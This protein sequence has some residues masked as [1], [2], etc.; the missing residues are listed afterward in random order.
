M[1]MLF[2]GWKRQKRAFVVL[3]RTTE[4]QF[5]QW[6][7]LKMHSASK[8]RLYLS[9]VP[10]LFMGRIRA[11]ETLLVLSRTTESRFMKWA[12]FFFYRSSFILQRHTPML[13]FIQRYGKDT[14]IVR[15]SIPILPC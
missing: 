6:A 4:S 15:L 14:A 10:L 8:R 1:A 12:V 5:M 3:S 11:K 13:R 9:T 7:V 2:L